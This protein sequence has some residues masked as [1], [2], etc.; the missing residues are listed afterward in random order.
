MNRGH[1]QLCLPANLLEGSS[2][3]DRMDKEP[4]AWGGWRGFPGVPALCLRGHVPLEDTDHSPDGSSLT[5]ASTQVPI[6]GHVPIGVLQEGTAERAPQGEFSS[7]CRNIS[8]GAISL[9]C[10]TPHTGEQVSQ[11]QDTPLPSWGSAHTSQ[12]PPTG[13]WR[14]SL[15]GR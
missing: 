14:R 7:P 4:V 6:L 3:G 11:S 8:L 5:P 9:L 13:S 10:R 2:S 12:R 1:C 15:P